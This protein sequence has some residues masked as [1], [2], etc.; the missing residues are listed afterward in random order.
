MK[1][2]AAMKAGGQKLSEIK[3]HLVSIAK[4]GVSLST[5]ESEAQRLI[6]ATGGQPSFAMVPN[7]HWATCINLN[8][9]LVHG[10]PDDKKIKEG[11]LVSI[12]VGLFLNGFHTDTSVS[13]ISTPKS[14][15]DSAIA[16]PKKTALLQ[17]GKKALAKA[18][19]QAKTGNHVGH[20]SQA[21]QVVVE[22]A[23]YSVARNLTG[24]GVGEQLHQQPM[25]PCFLKTP[26]EETPI[27][28]SGLTLAIEVI[29]MAG[30]HQTI[31]DAEDNWTVRTEDGN[32]AAVFEE[33]IVVS[34]GGPVVLTN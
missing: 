21:I 1:K 6:K 29:Y 12:D 16:Y 34:K 13:F 2:I 19:V 30:F 23:G 14:A 5:I 32:L 27:I 9:G 11:D 7:Y 17:V 28:Q 33:T 22:S 20:I 26:L 18:I 15:S 31:T 4:P 24:H 3:H 8:D 10:V 25:I